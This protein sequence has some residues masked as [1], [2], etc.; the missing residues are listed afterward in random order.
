MSMLDL[1]R[2]EL[3]SLGALTPKLNAIIQRVTNAIP[4][5]T[6]SE[7]MKAVIAVTQIT[8]FA[9]QFRRNLQLWD[10]T[11]VPIN[12]ISFVI[13]GSGA[14][15]DSSVRAAERC[16][17]VGYEVLEKQVTQQ[18]KLA[19]I[20]A[21]AEAGEELPEEFSIYK[22]YMMPIP[23]VNMSITTGPGLI[24]HIN[25]IEALP[26]T[27]GLL[28]SGE[29]GDELYANPDAVENI[30]I[31]SEVY[32]LGRKEQNYTKG[33]EHRSKAINGQPVSAL[34]VGSPTYL[35]Y[36]EG[37]KRKFQI[38]FMSKLARRSWFCYSPE[39]IPEPTF[40]TL[41]E[42]MDYE[43]KLEYTA[44]QARNVMS[45]FIRDL[46]AWGMKSSG[47]PITVSD[48]VFR[49]F[50]VYKRYNS[51]FADNLPN[52]D[53]TY[54][55]I[56][57][58]LQWK[59]LKLAG[60]FAF[61]DKSDVV[62]KQH[63]IEAMQFC[64]LLD[65]DMIAFER[66]LNK[67]YYERFSDYIRSQVQPDGKAIINIHDIKKHGFLTNVALPKLKELVT[68]CAG[69]DKDG[70]YT[71]INDGAAIQY[72]PIIKTDVIGISFKP[73]NTSDLNLAV[74]SGDEDA[75]RKAKHDISVTTAYGYE[76]GE[77]TFADL[78]EL[79]SSDFAYSPFRFHNGVRGKDNI[80]GG[81]KWCVFDIDD[82]IISA[83]EAHFMLS[84][85]RHHIALSSDPDNEYKF[86]ILIEFDSSVDVNAQIWKHFLSAIA[87]DLAIKIDPLPQSQIFFSYANRKVYSNLDADP[88]PVRDYIM[89]ANDRQAA[90][91]EKA[92]QF[93][94]SQR[95]T[96]LDDPLNS[97]DYAYN[98]PHGSGSRNMI[99][100]AYHAKDLGA[101]LSETL[102]LI[103]N[104]NEYWDSP[105]NEE[106]L[107]AI[108]RQVERMF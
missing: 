82:S 81:T 30:K 14:G 62:Q 92:K 60:A 9:S 66:D 99:R 100:A 95:R 46:T 48:D 13:V 72:E 68:L 49:L 54:A 70:I 25:D 50:K 3:E 23:P 80:L 105:M 71:V 51:D 74:A 86:R 87:E 102:E 75:I 18:V 59:A 83:S 79:L 45:D 32:D 16:F 98:S 15:K 44:K 35:L 53:S 94:P 97:F 12:A 5:P 69:Y 58:H 93:T 67:Q 76:L 47:T 63:Y 89:Q 4:F 85:I 40:N 33:V 41:D 24:R 20:R 36:D 78:G 107:D 73:I 21:A 1:A 52:Q 22:K 106:R 34:F 64:E 96:M 42:M 31:L 88:L 108:L 26:L 6:V 101:T 27:A 91:D 65:H 104:V 55:L 43:E 38:A 17:T 19:A 7:R 103:T 37:T 61:F 11:P 28:Y 84:D 90:K 57:R 2:N 10:N 39:K 8:T 77:T 56:R 29:F